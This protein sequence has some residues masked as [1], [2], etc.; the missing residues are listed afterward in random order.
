[1]I[2]VVTVYNRERSLNEILLPSLKN[3]TAR[4]EF[5]P[6]TPKDTY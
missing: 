1:M 5:I 2:S 3:Q 4:P 6:I